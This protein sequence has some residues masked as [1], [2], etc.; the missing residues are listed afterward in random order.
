MA[1]FA[2][3]LRVT[4]ER[5]KC[6]RF[7]VAEEK[8]EIIGCIALEGLERGKGEVRTFF[9]APEHQGRGVGRRLMLALVTIA[10]TQGISRLQ[11]NADPV[12]VK[13]YENFG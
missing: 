6:C 5:I 7:W 8:G 12:S 1:K 13:H 11:E 10:H 4:P 3:G 9:V 2:D